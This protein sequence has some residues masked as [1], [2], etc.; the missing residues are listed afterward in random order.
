MRDYRKLE[1]ALALVLGVSLSSTASAQGY[2]P[3]RTGSEGLVFKTGRLVL[4]L[5]REGTSQTRRTSRFGVCR[6]VFDS[7]LY[8]QRLSSPT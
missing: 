4:H 3:D 2:L 6:G 5:S 7:Y 8:A 1:L